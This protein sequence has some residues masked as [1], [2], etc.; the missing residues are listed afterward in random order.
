MWMD[1]MPGGQGN[2]QLRRQYET[3]LWVLMGVVALVLLIACAN[4]ASLL[5]ARAS[6][7]RKEIAIRLALGS[8]R[9]RLV[10]QLLTESLLL[11]VIGGAAGIGLSV[12]MIKSLLGFLPINVSGYAISSTPDIR[13]SFWLTAGPYNSRGNLFR[14]DPRACNP[15]GPIFPKRSRIRS[16][17]RRAAVCSSGSVKLLVAFQVTLS[18]VLLIGAGVFLR[19]TG[20][21]GNPGLWIPHVR[22]AGIQSGH[23]R[24]RLR[25]GSR[26]RLLRTPAGPV[27]EYSRRHFRRD[28]PTSRS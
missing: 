11:A 18:L 24:R 15:P 3:P 26:P 19:S 6:A 28:S 12:M 25:S 5:T 16:Q 8:S 14:A 20:Q 2:T 27:A 4:L 1:A 9:P 22:C 13:G 21:S 23:A 17:N 10:Q 7:R